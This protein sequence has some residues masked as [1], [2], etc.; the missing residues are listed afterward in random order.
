LGGALEATTGGVAFCKTFS[1]FFS[2]FFGSV[3][4]SFLGSST[5]TGLEE[6]ASGAIFAS[7]ATGAATLSPLFNF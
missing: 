1:C 3:I 7:L 6:C 4:A 2:S 5:A